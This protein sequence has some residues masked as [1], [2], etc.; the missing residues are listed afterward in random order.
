MAYA[1]P[2]LEGLGS[3]GFAS[4][5]H[6]L[7]P[8]ADASRLRAVSASRVF[9]RCLA[10]IDEFSAHDDALLAHPLHFWIH[11]SVMLSSSALL[12]RHQG[13]PQV[14]SVL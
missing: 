3:L 13:D 1:P 10:E 14:D 5:A 11:S 8:A 12:R 2:L 4:Q 9:A 7:R 6:D